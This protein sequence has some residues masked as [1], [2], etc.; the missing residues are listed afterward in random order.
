MNILEKANEIVNLRKEEKERQ[1]GP[2]EQGMDRAA[3]ILS[4]M[5]GLELDAVFIYK[6]MIALKLSRES[7]NHKEDNL[8]DCVSY[9][10]S[11]NNY[12][13]K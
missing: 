7:Y 10:A 12:F 1:Y 2:F 3:K 13:N 8:L 5:T 6:A 9:I 11:L 4:G